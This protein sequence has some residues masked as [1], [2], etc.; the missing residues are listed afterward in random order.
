MRAKGEL[1]YVRLDVLVLEI[2][3][4]LPNV[5][6]DY[7]NM[8]YK[9][10]DQCRLINIIIY[11]LRRGSWLAVVTISKTLLEELKPC[12]DSNQHHCVIT[13]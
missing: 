12:A 10:V 7:G 5:D 6:T 8:S 4:M 9:Y 3:G 2:E 1:T 13:E 11:V